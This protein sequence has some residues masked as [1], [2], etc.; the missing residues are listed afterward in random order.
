MGP[1]GSLGFLSALR[2]ALRPLLCCN[3]ASCDCVVLRQV[4]GARGLTRTAGDPWESS[5]ENSMTLPT[6]S[7][8]CAC[9]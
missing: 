2:E 9:S 5:Q 8:F 6:L 7:P 4:V 3:P 1:P